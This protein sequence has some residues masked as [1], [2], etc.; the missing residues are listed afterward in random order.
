MG[1]L[2]VGERVTVWPIWV[3][4]G[5]VCSFEMPVLLTEIAYDPHGRAVTGDV[6]STG[7]VGSVGWSDP[8]RAQNHGAQWTGRVETR[9]T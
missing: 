9:A 2:A 6:L 3:I 8:G 4:E 5:V 7:P 1:A